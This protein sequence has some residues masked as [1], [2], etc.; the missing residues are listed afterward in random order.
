M[1]TTGT[2]IARSRKAELLSVLE[3][4][5]KQQDVLV[6]IHARVERLNALMLQEARLRNIHRKK[7][8]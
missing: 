8:I 2:Q 7:S 1:I 3:E 5:R 4:Y 6:K